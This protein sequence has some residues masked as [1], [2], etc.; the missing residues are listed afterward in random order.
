MSV[1]VTEQI[2]MAFIRKHPLT[3]DFGEIV[4]DR[5]YKRMK[6]E[7]PEKLQKLQT[8]WEHEV[9][10]AKSEVV[11]SPL[12]QMM[13]YLETLS[14]KGVLK[15]LKLETGFQWSE[16]SRLDFP[17]FFCTA[18]ADFTVEC[19]S[20]PYFKSVGAYALLHN[21]SV[22]DLDKIEFDKDKEVSLGEIAS[23]L[24]CAIEYEMDYGHER[25]KR[26]VFMHDGRKVLEEDTNIVWVSDNDDFDS[27]YTNE[28]YGEKSFVELIEENFE[29]D[30]ISCTLSGD[31]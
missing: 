5:D 23:S 20:F 29:Q 4:S 26:Q 6:E 22:E 1:E 30:Q 11:F 8:E 27:K 19:R 16:F 25:M 12:K 14:R 10:G 15:G 24:G 28:D 9:F 13:Q 2:K 17:D 7:E 3:R 21:L 18:L 31:A